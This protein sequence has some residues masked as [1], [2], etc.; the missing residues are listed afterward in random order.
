MGTQGTAVSG[1]SGGSVGDGVSGFGVTGALVA[2]LVGAGVS[3]FGVDGVV[4]A[5]FV[6]AGVSGFGVTGASVT[7]VG[8]RVTG[9]E[10][11]GFDVTEAVDG[12]LV[13]GLGVD[14][15]VGGAVTA[16]QNK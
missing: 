14:G 13:V 3:G 12:A 1:F 4:V 6:G 9:T 11:S 5:L 2:F 10:V 15:I 7:C 8:G 16:G